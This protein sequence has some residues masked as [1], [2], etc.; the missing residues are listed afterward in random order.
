MKHLAVWLFDQRI[1]TLL[2]DKSGRM[3]Y[4]YESDA[5]AALSL[6]MPVQESPYE[7]DLCESFF[8]G[9]LPESD[10]ARQLIGRRFGVNGNNSFSLLGV[11]GHE[12][13]GA[14]SIFPDDREPPTVSQSAA[15]VLGEKALADHI[16][17][18]PRRPLL[19]GVEGIRLSLAGAGDK[20]A[21]CVVDGQIALPSAGAL[22]SHV[23]KPNIGTI[24]DTVSNEFFCMKLAERLGMRAA[25]VEFRTAK[26]I[27]FLL[28]KRY[29]RSYDKNGNLTRIHQED[30]CQ[31]LGVVSAQKYQN[32]GGPGYKDC[33]ELLRRVSRPAIDR[34]R[35]TEYAIF[36]FL[37]G[38]MD[39]HGKNFSLLHGATLSLA[40][41]YD[42]LSTKV[43]PQLSARLAMRVD[44]YYEPD[45]IFPRHWKRLYEACGMSY[46]A[47]KRS[48]VDSCGKIVGTAE[49]LRDELRKVGHQQTY[50][51]I[52]ENIGNTSKLMSKRFDNETT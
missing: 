36:N 46:P 42:V 9:L 20:A 25:G 43:Y 21:V 8:G 24:G 22:T 11:I 2:Q 40:P 12:C 52:V 31:A 45:K 19:A 28:V 49:M 37:I 5:V 41:L 15:N 30:F 13:A 39:A 7:H 14:I 3:S 35:F 33:F 6:S 38:N 29:D 47:F 4:T 18:L 16:R 23:I 48:F 1:G 34:N 27:E 17:D 44:K 50:D 51:A 10:Q 26:D 32:E